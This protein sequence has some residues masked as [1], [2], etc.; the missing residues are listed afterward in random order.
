MTISTMIQINLRKHQY[1]TQI[2]NEPE[3]FNKSITNLERKLSVRIIQERPHWL[4]FKYMHFCITKTEFIYFT[5]SLKQHTPHFIPFS[6]LFFPIHPTKIIYFKNKNKRWR[7]RKNMQIQY[8]MHD[9]TIKNQNSSFVFWARRK[10]GQW[11]V[12]T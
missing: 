3:G 9:I 6:F 5:L 7:K 2:L 4:L 11:V 10:A 8:Y 12:E 1:Q